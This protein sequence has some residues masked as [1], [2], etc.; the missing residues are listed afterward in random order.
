MKKN[1][2]VDAVRVFNHAAVGHHHAGLRDTHSLRLQKTA[3]YFLL[4]SAAE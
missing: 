2:K 1:K 3:G 4:R